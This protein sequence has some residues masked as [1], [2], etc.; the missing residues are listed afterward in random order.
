MVRPRARPTKEFTER[1]RPSSAS[2]ITQVQFTAV[3][4]KSTLK[5]RR[6]VLA[7]DVRF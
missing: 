7:A 4:L 6:R 2:F 1:L 5:R 3:Q